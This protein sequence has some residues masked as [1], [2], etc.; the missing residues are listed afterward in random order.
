[1]RRESPVALGDGG[2]VEWWS[3][4]VAEWRNDGTA[5]PPPQILKDR[6]TEW[7][8]SFKSPEILKD[9][10]AKSQLKS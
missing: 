2:T 10:M 5:E 6:I 8:N 7:W 3:G 4:G 9:G 1:M